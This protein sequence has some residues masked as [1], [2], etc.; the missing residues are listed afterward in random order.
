MRGSAMLDLLTYAAPKPEKAKEDTMPI[1]LDPVDSQAVKLL[2]GIAEASSMRRGR[3]L[4]FWSGFYL[5]RIRRFSRLPAPDFISRLM[6]EADVPATLF[7]A[8]AALDAVDDEREMMRAI[9][10]R[11]DLLH[12]LAYDARKKKSA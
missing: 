2:A 6:R 3:G 5:N 7:D 10:E 1:E 9:R 12:A 11:A 8:R 4:E